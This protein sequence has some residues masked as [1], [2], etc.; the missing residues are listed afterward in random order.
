[1]ATVRHASPVAFI[2]LAITFALSVPLVLG[3][4]KDLHPAFDSFAHFRLHL[5]VLVAMAALPLL[6]RAMR[7]Q[8]LGLAAFAGARPIPTA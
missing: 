8:T 2:A 3:F 1:M 6:F 4:L 5:A 7:R